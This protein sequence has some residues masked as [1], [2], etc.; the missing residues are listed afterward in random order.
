MQHG[1]PKHIDIPYNPLV[2]DKHDLNI[3][4]YS[5]KSGYC[6]LVYIYIYISSSSFKV[7]LYTLYNKK[8]QFWFLLCVPILL[9][10]YLGLLDTPFLFKRISLPKCLC[11]DDGLQDFLNF[12]TSIAISAPFN[13]TFSLILLGCFSELEIIQ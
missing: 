9:K 6:C 11:G 10:F 12:W 13:K 8:F 4:G 1:S 2:F 5:F 3:Y 7:K